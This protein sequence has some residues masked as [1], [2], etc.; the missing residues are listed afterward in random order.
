MKKRETESSK[1]IPMTEIQNSQIRRKVSINYSTGSGLYEK[2]HY[3]GV[4][5]S[6]SQIDSYGLK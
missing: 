4:V 2:W 6:Y 1:Q 3:T 5:K